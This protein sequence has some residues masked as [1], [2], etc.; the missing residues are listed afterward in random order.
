MN[1]SIGLLSELSMCYRQ[2]KE[3]EDLIPNT[4]NTELAAKTQQMGHTFTQDYC[5]Q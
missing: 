3:Q 5:F 4:A 1:Q 2:E